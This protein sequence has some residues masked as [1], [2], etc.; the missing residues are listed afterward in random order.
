MGTPAADDAEHDHADEAFTVDQLAAAA[1]TMT[2][3]VRM[4]QSR[5]LLAPPTRQ[6]R[7]ARY[8]SGHLERLRV[9]AELQRRGHSLAG[10]KELLAGVDDG[11]P[12]HELV[13]VRTWGEPTRRTLTVSELMTRFAAPLMPADV[14]RAV[15]L[16]LVEPVG[17]RVVV[18]E[19][20]LDLGARLVQL[21]LPVTVVLDEWERLLEDARVI[22][23]RFSALFDD[24]L[25]DGD[26]HLPEIARVL[27]ELGP[28]A[29][30][31]TRLA[32]ERALADE[33]R[34]FASRH[35]DVRT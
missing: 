2:S 9:I 34:R 10:I 35:G 23:H 21:G 8:G 13:G 25:L 20:F 3:T 22:A 27:D 14:T 17:D 32:L 7:V 26:A 31:V 1:G 33:A 4:Y 12:L 24:H 6:G 28:L 29:Q 11:R 30:D 5:G 18:D 16:G 19:R 15:G